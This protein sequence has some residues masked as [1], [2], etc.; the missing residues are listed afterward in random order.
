MAYVDYTKHKT[1]YPNTLIAETDFA[2]LAELASLVVDAL[3]FQR[4]KRAG[5]SSFPAATVDSIERATSAQ[6]EYFDSLGGIE[7]ATGN[8]AA[9]NDV[10]VGKFSYAEGSTAA[11]IAP[12]KVAISPVAALYLEPTGLT[13]AGVDPLP[14]G[15]G[16]C[17]L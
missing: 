5:I 9:L 4:I 6:I 11:G 17:V 12:G 7:A 13:Y 2:P 15:D 10:T 8:A 3:T 16:W 14:R 1:F